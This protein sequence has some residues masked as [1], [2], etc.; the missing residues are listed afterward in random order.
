MK[1]RKEGKKGFTS[2]EGG[3]EGKGNKVKEGLPQGKE[4]RKGR[5]ILP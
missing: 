5:N 3:K 1:Q 2:R 4:Q